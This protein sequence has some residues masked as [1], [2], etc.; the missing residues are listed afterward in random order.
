M[1]VYREMPKLAKFEGLSK[2]PEHIIYDYEQVREMLK[3]YGESIINECAESAKIDVVY[4]VEDDSKEG[5]HDEI[6]QTSF[7]WSLGSDWKVKAN[8]ETILAIKEKII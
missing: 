4:G 1:E 3:R 7:Q 8:K 6:T 2:T 5:C